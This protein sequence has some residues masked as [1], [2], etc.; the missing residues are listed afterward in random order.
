M[1]SPHTYSYT[2]VHSLHIEPTTPCVHIA[3]Q[4]QLNGPHALHTSQVIFSKK[5]KYI[6][7]DSFQNKVCVHVPLEYIQRTEM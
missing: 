5:K 1:L 7:F 4:L 6:Y 2:P 3:L